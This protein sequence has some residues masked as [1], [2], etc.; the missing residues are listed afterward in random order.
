MKKKIVAA[1][2][3]CGVGALA[4]AQTS[5]QL[6]GRLDGGLEY[7]NNLSTPDGG[8]ASRW[9]AQGG[10]YGTSLFGLRGY[11]DLGR[12]LHAVFNLEAGFQLMNGTNNNGNGSLFNRRALV[13][14]ASNQWGTFT[15]GRNLFISNGV[16]DFDPFQQ[17]GFSSASLV[18][19][20]NWPQASNTLNYQSPN[21]YGLDFAGQYA[22]SN[23]AG[24]FNNGRAAGA[25]VTYTHERFQLRAMYDE[26]RDANGRF[27]DIFSSSREYFAGAN[28]F[29]NRF[30]FQLAY[31]HMSAPDAPVP[32][33]ATKADHYWVGLKY[34][35]TPVWALSSAVYHV[36][37]PGG[38][39]NATMFEIG[40]TY[41]LSKRTFFYGTV[42]YTRNSSNANFSVA[43][44]AGDSLDN[45]PPGRN[46]T[47]A[48]IGISHSF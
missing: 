20:R 46:Q 3:L 33:L 40:T 47:G 44:N 11:E 2:L 31:T 23:V 10:D 35:A 43:V 37:V 6:Y 38:F 45:P 21:I 9:R 4:N 24:Q 18:R 41:A 16:W 27:S 39:G 7:M 48:Y 13:G 5:M 22:L 36:N 8:T 1:T 19:G 26:I 29:L 17:Q 30:T 34:Q 28:I 15:M 42:A 25:Q 32:E 12:G 14:F